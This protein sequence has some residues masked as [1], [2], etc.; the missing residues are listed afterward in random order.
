MPVDSQDSAQSERVRAVEAAV[1]T[2]SKQLI[3]LGGRNRLLFYRD[4]KVGT[5]DI[6]PLQAASPERFSDLLAGNAVLL[7][8]LVP[9]SQLRLSDSLDGDVELP[10]TNGLEDVERVLKRARALSAKAK[11]NF[12]EKGLRTLQLG[13]GL[14][15]WESERSDSTPAAAVVLRPVSL[16]PVGTAGRDFSI[17]LLGEWTVNDALLHAL[18]LDFDAA[19]TISALVILR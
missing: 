15:S 12:D 19:P 16:E 3:D 5:M 4:L 17:R 9:Q 13:W 11:E 7:T 18:R 10:S 14:A 8:Q 2:W 6:A 1:A